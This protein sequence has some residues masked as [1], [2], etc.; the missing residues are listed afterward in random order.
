MDKYLA[1]NPG[2]N[3]LVGHSYGSSAVLGK[4]KQDNKHQIVHNNI[5][6]T[7]I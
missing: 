3:T 2:I 1:E 4:Q 5:V 7:I 6:F